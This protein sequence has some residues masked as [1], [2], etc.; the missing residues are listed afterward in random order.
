MKLPTKIPSG[1]AL[2]VMIALVVSCTVNPSVSDLEKGFVNPPDS[3]RPGVWWHWLNG[4]ISKEGITRDLEAM[5]A[6]GIGEASIFNLRGQAGQGPVTYGSVQWQECVNHAF[7]EANRLKLELS[8]Q[9]CGGWATSGGPWVTPD[10]AMKKLTYKKLRVK[11]RQ[12][13]S[14]PLNTPGHTGDYYRDVS[15]LAYP[16]AD[17]EFFNEMAPAIQSVS[18]DKEILNREAICDGDL[19]TEASILADGGNV[20]LLLEFKHPIEARSVFLKRTWPSWNGINDFVLMA[21]RDNKRF[22]KLLET[23]IRTD[24]QTFEFHPVKARFFKFIIKGGF[25]DILRIPEIQFNRDIHD[26]LPAL[27][28]LNALAGYQVRE[29]INPKKI[30]NDRKAPV[31]L[32][33]IVDLTANLNSNGVF[34]W[35]VP[36]GNWT[37]LR[38]GY[39]LTGKKNEGPPGSTGLESDKLSAEAT[40]A[41]YN[42]MKEVLFRDREKYL[43]NTLRSILTDSW[44]CLNV[45]W[46]QK[47]PEE[48][49]KR[50]GYSIYPYL[51]VIAGELVEN[52][53]VSYR[54][55]WDFRRTISDLIAENYYGEMAGLCHQNGIKLESEAA[56]AQQALKD[57]INYS[58]RADIPMTEFWVQPFKPNG[59]FM[60]AVSAGHLYGKK[61][62]SA[63]SFTSPAGD[64][65]LTPSDLKTFGDKAFCWGINMFRFHSYTLQA[66]ETFPGWQMNP[67]GIAINRKMPWWDHL[68]GYF[69]YLQRAQFMLQ[70]GQFTADVLLFCSE[71]AQTDLNSSYGNQVLAYLPQG[72]RFDGCDRNT[73]LNRLKVKDHKLVLPDGSSYFLLV[74]PGNLQITPVLLEKIKELVQ[75][76]ATVYGP[77]PI[78]SPSLMDYPGCDSQVN[79]LSGEIW[80]EPD[81]SGVIEHS[82][83]RGRVIYGQPIGTVLNG[84]IIPDFDYETSGALDSLD[85][86]H[87]IYGDTDIYFVSNLE[88]HPVD[89]TGKFR[90]TGKVPEVWDPETGLINRYVEYRQNSAF[91]S[92]P[93]SMEPGSSCFVVFTHPGGRSVHEVKHARSASGP[94]PDPFALTGPWKVSF[95][96]NWGGPGEVVF[97]SLVSWTER[98]EEGIKFYS[99]RVTYEK[100]FTMDAALLKPDR[101]IYLDLGEIRETA[102]VFLNEKKVGTFWKEPF[103]PEISGFVEP[104]KNKLVVEVANGWSNRIIGDLNSRDGK[105]YTWSNSNDHYTKDSELSGSG[106]TGPV[107]I[108]F[109]S[110]KTDIL[111]PK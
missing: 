94:V 5:A 82:F 67:W 18:C 55:L 110:L 68:S 108:R 84:M 47:F 33:E 29:R 81:R 59:S 12:R 43:G 28:D 57:P 99:G 3:A 10:N 89:A 111:H 72:Y 39:T 54:F 17:P 46:T 31:K 87:R 11:G 97:D 48:F 16:T 76:G 23:I 102:R 92:V 96:K 90:V 41:Y 93:L 25:Q 75:E 22:D 1:I 52:D 85:F 61:V 21:S 95:D 36:E 45:N 35:E 107:Y 77:K 73:I 69:K 86:I 71:G 44:E 8:F 24:F 15:I 51:A 103:K 60:D 7:A 70:Q 58:S 14:A 30:L 6:Q 106:L 42:G 49:R 19:V 83:G 79:R 13:F 100:E 56:G 34:T 40:R 105:R 37:L 91:T 26:F 50:R 53:E 27:N 62:I 74:L 78:Q 9:N 2:I 109:V 104:G 64:W 98:P 63:E 65:K 66:D 80:G 101:K 38:M 4:N 32:S 88:S 20:T